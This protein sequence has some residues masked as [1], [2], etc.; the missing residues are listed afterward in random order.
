M[1]C[2]DTLTSDR[3]EVLLSV[4]RSN[5]IAFNGWDVRDSELHQ[6]GALA[7]IALDLIRAEVTAT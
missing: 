1:R 5:V 6:N 4:R 7:H 3:L 2:G